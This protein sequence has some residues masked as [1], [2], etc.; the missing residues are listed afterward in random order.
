M[1]RSELTPDA[2][3]FLDDID[4]FAREVTPECY[5][6]KVKSLDVVIAQGYV[7][8]GHISSWVHTQVSAHVD[9]LSH[10]CTSLQFRYNPHV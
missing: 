10:G 1:K 7:T 3:A 2:L 5:V 4:V 9:A 6:V 8:R